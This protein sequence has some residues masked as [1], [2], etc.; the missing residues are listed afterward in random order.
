VGRARSVSLRHCFVEVTRLGAEVGREVALYI[1]GGKRFASAQVAALVASDPRLLRVASGEAFEGIDLAIVQLDAGFLA[2]LEVVSAEAAP[3][4]SEALVLA[5]APAP[6]AAPPTAAPAPA[7]ADAPKPESAV[8]R[9]RADRKPVRL[10]TRLWG[11]G[12]EVQ[13][14]TRNISPLGAF[15]ELATPLPRDTA[16]HLELELPDRLFHYEAVV[17]RQQA[18]ASGSAGVGVRFVTMEEALLH[19]PVLETGAAPDALRLDLRD[20]ALLASVYLSEIRHGGLSVVS[21]ERYAP[22]QVVAIDLL[23]PPPVGSH[24]L[25]ARVLHFDAA[26]GR[27]AVEMLDARS[28]K[29]AIFQILSEHQ[30][31]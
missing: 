22:D 27:L 9:R 10:P 14:I 19:V 5:Q 12:I 29:Q 25:Q 23:L 11:G 18:A 24:A 4:T 8:S 13:G 28:V 3:R 6:P 21:T 30:R 15:I 7:P 1:P 31:R 20:P 17:V 26:K 16:F 2:M